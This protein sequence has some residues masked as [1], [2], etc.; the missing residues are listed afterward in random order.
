MYI[1]L[2]FGYLDLQAGVAGD[3]HEENLLVALLALG[4]ASEEETLRFLWQCTQE[5]NLGAQRAT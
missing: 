5:L 4:P 3:H 1:Y 2:T